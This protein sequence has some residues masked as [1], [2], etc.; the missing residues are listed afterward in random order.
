MRGDRLREARQLT[1]RELAARCGL[2]EKQIWRYENNESDPTGDYVARIARE[3]EVSADYL[4]G[5][6]EKPTDHF[7]PEELTVDE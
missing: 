1:Q 4:L 5:L 7:I 3:L 6:A 2:G